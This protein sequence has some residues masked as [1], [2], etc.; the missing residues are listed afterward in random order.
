MPIRM[1]LA[2]FASAIA[3][4]LLPNAPAHAFSKVAAS[5]ATIQLYAAYSINPDCS[6]SGQPIIRIT[7]SP[8]YGRLTTQATRVFPRFPPNNP[9]SICNARGAPGLKLFYRS[10]RGY[11]GQDAVAIDVFY[12]NGQ[13]QQSSFDITVR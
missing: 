10:Q 7:Q 1:R 9:R 4:A 12:P 13:N 6:A 2:V 11:V 5:G 8:Q 3:M